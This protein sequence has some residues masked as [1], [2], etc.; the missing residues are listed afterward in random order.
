MNLFIG[1][2]IYFICVELIEALLGLWL[3]GTKKYHRLG[4]RLIAMG[5]LTSWACPHLCCS[6]CDGSCRNWTCPNYHSPRDQ[7]DPASS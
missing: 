3:A 5:V 7:E 6:D 1:F 4:I 2:L